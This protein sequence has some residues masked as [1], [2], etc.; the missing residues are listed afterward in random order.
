MTTTMILGS[1]M[2]AWGATSRLRAEGITPA[3][4]DKNVYPGGHTATFENRGF[5]FDDGPHISFTSVERMQGVFSDAVDGRY[6]ILRADV[7]N[8]YQGHW[9][10][11]PAIANLYA[12]SLFVANRDGVGLSIS[13]DHPTDPR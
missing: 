1:G 13:S 3:L 11:H 4:F 10:V 5:Y 9:V 12:S 7:D 8:W 6:E 2:A